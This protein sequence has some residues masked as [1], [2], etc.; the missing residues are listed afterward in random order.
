MGIGHWALVNG[1]WALGIADQLWVIRSLRPPRLCASVVITQSQG[2][3]KTLSQHLHRLKP[4]CQQEV[5]A[6]VL[7]AE[8]TGHVLVRQSAFVGVY[9]LHKPLVR[10]NHF[11]NASFLRST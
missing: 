5:D 7:Q 2:F 11:F 1:Q 4:R 9:T 3:R 10:E 6:L 8:F